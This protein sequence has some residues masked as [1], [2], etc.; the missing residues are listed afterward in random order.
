KYSLHGGYKFVLEQGPYKKSYGKS[1]EKSIT[2]A[3]MYKMQDKF[4]QLDLGL[5]FHY[6]P[7]VIGFWYRGLPVKRYK[8]GYGNYDAVAVLLGFKQEKFSF[9]YS[10]D[11]TISRL[12]PTNTAGSHEIS[13]S[14][15]INYYG[16]DLKKKPKMRRRDMVI[17]CPKF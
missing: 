9:G 2:P 15:V 14:Y 13:L 4:D 5:Y 17:P 3:F 11:L 7:L 10:Y 6:E 12:G 8:P 16:N 1:K